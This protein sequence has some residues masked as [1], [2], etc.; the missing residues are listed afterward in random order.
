MSVIDPLRLDDAQLAREARTPLRQVAADAGTLT[1]RN[2]LR[3]TRNPELIVFAT[4]Q[5]IIFVL[6]FVYVFGGA[7]KTGSIPYVDFLMAGRPPEDSWVRVARHVHERL[8]REY[9]DPSDPVRR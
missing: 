8:R 6:M 9:P 1:W 2:L 3:L 4:I 7:I 5:P